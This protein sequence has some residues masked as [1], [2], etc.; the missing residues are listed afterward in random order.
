MIPHRTK[1]RELVVLAWKRYFL[2]LKE[3]LAVLYII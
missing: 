1:F 2:A 3:D